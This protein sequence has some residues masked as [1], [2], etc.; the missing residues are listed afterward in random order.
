MSIRSIVEEGHRDDHDELL[1]VG[2]NM[3]VIRSKPVFG[4]P[5]F[6]NLNR[7]RVTSYY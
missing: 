7:N 2:K 5:L 4:T 3:V 1:I 6:V